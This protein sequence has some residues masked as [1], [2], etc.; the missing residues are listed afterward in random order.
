MRI[1]S[2]NNYQFKIREFIM[3]LV[4]SSIALAV[5]ASSYSVHADESLL[6]YIKGAETLPKG[7]WE[8]DQTF[9]YRDDKGAGDYTA[10][11]S[12]TEIEYGVTDRFT[13]A[14]YLKMQSIDMSGIVVDGYLPGDEDYGLRP[15]GVEASF[16]YMFL[17]PAKDDFGLAGYLSLGYDWLD[18]HSGQDKDKYAIELE[19]LAQKYFMEG[20]LVWA[21]NIGTEAAYAKRD[22]LSAGRLASLP[23]GYDWPEDAEMEI[24]MKAGTGLSY[25][26]APNWYIGAETLYETE[27]ETEVGQERWSWFAGPSLH[28]GGKDWWATVT[29]FKQIKGGGEKFEE[30]D[31][32][33]LHLIE[34][35][36]QEVRVKVGFEF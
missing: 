9:T 34:K 3:R 11:D 20:Q 32:N 2:I 14:A 31:D 5:L 23:A 30:Q 8:L 29:W 22:G 15:S 27:F 6:G 19:L 24:E 1:V 16:K 4:T 18:K 26:F 17:S 7:S 10:W 13:A 36:K 33:D 25:R 35:T 12:K 21:A 28:Y